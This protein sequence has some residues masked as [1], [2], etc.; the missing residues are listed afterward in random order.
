MT[1][2]AAP[3]AGLCET[4]GNVRVIDTRKGSRFFLCQLSET[5][6]RFA[7]YPR[8]PLLRCPGYTPAPAPAEEADP[9]AR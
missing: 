5:D 7:K 3:H 2:S 9:V 1:G 6:P 8:T 4:C